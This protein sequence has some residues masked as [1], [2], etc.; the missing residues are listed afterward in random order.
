[1]FTTEAAVREALNPYKTLF[2]I[3]VISSVTMIAMSIP[4]GLLVV[5]YY[6]QGGRPQPRHFGQLEAYQPPVSSSWEPPEFCFRPSDPEHMT[7]DVTSEHKHD[8]SMNV[9]RVI[10]CYYNRSRV[11]YAYDKRWYGISTIPYNLCRYVLYG[12]MPIHRQ[13][14]EIVTTSRD[15][16]LIE[17]LRWRSKQTGVRLIVSVYGSGEFSRMSSRVGHVAL[18][19][20]SLARWT[21]EYGFH[22]VHIGWEALGVPP[23]GDPGDKE[24]LTQILEHVRRLSHINRLNLTICVTN[25][26]TPLSKVVDFYFDSN[27]HCEGT[28]PSEFIAHYRQVQGWNAG[29]LCASVSA[30]LD[31]FEVRGTVKTY[32]GREDYGKICPLGAIPDGLCHY[33]NKREPGRILRYRYNTLENLR[34]KVARISRALGGGCYVYFDGDMDAVGYKCASWVFPNLKAI[35]DY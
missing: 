22:G 10:F 29:K 12:P 3:W 33:V 8:L 20:T 27:S 14:P 35:A 28:E 7:T 6:R 15:I 13:R 26:G 31:A 16:L 21:K 9:S 11:N 18:F 19:A 34:D 5:H 17:A 4:A 32:L 25:V 23:C 30:T 24:A 2:I 1:M